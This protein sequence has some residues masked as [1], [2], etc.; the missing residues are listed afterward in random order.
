MSNP[1]EYYFWHSGGTEQ[2]N[3]SGQTKDG[4]LMS[5]Q[6]TNQF[7]MTPV[8]LSHSSVPICSVQTDTTCPEREHNC[9]YIL[10][11]CRMTH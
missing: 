9:S 4:D 7:H 8:L 6:N 1:Q 3:Q 10:M 2:F 5:V 11:H